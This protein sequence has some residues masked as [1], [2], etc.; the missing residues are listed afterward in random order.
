[1]KAKAKKILVSALSAVMIGALLLAVGLSLRMEGSTTE[2]FFSGDAQTYYESLLDA[3]FPKD[4]AVSLTELHLLHPNWVFL[5]LQITQTNEAYTWDYVIKKETEN[6]LTNLIPASQTYQAYHHPL[7]K[8]QYD[9]GYYQASVDTV[10]Y[11]MD[12]RNFLNEADIFQFY[13]LSYQ[14][15]ATLQE[16]EAVLNGT[17]MENGTLENGRSYA[18]YL[19]EVGQALD[20]HPVYLAAKIRQ[21]QGSAG[22]S[23]IISGRCGSLLADY[24]RNQTQTSE[25]GK[26]ILPP[27]SGYTVEQ[28]CALDGYYNMF[29]VKASGTGLFQIYLNAMNR[30]VDGTAEMASAWGGSAAWNTR[31]KSIYGG[32]Y[33]LKKNYID[34]YQSTVYLQKFNVDGRAADRNFWGQYMQNVAGAL[35]EARSLYSAFA[36]V[37]AL[38]SACTFLIPV[39]EGMPDAPCKDPANGTCTLLAQAPNRYSY[40]VELT[41]PDRLLSEDST[42][43][44]TLYPQSE[45]TLRLSGRVEHS[46]GIRVLQYRLDDGEWITFSTS[47]K[48]DLSIPMQFL[49]GSKHILTVRGWANYDNDD[50]S[51][52]QNHS[53]L[54]AVFYL[55]MQ[56]TQHEIAFVEKDSSTT[57]THPK[58]TR[59]E[60]PDCALPY[61]VGWIGSDGSFLPAGA[62]IELTRDLTYTATT[63]RF[64]L[65]HG[66]SL[67]LK[68]TPPQ[69]RFSAVL[70]LE[71]YQALK[72]QDRIRLFATLQEEG[73]STPASI[74]DLRE[75]GDWVKISVD[76]PPVT[77]FE[78]LYSA[79]FSIEVRYSNGEK[80]TLCAAGEPC[81]RSVELVA[82]AALNDASVAYSQ[83]TLTYLRDLLSTQ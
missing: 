36:A 47:E 7:N 4:Y 18:A 62:Q 11:F 25:N 38:D 32:S 50:P 27:S 14:T 1:M 67:S 61:F 3:G 45:K 30:A 16:I 5:P 35:T 57:Q 33:L 74:S 51:Q 21:E 46:Y 55:E 68:G 31:W 56:T 64:F 66:A 52:K 77:N 71:D 69:L 60:L 10:R 8:E 83:Q 23:A 65:L 70:A 49:A 28:L 20:L 9:S 81:D 80:Q 17:F 15:T 26:K 22:T 54:C 78:A 72:S 73:L 79:A 63:A 37:D 6:P 42:V 34:R 43:Y 82:T 76:T 19:Q 29:N 39:Y 48:L 24:Y 12:P 40:T 2:R 53:F 13:D 41:S 44:Q 59:L 58:G 75:L